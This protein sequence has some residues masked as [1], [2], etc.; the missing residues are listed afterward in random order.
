MATTDIKPAYNKLKEA[1]DTHIENISYQAKV[2]DDDL[3]NDDSNENDLVEKIREL[4]PEKIDILFESYCSSGLKNSASI[5]DISESLR[6]NIGKPLK[7]FSTL[8][9]KFNSKTISG[10]FI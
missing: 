8:S 9:N 4:S 6:A 10:L 3:K 1:L 2:D 7:L 5:S